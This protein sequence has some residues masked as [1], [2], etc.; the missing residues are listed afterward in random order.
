MCFADES[1]RVY[2]VLQLRRRNYYDLENVCSHLDEVQ[3]VVVEE[4]GVEDSGK[5]VSYL[6]FK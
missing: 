2:D 6:A 1:A 4:F 5:L 3:Y